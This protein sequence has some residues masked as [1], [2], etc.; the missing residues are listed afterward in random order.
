MN[1]EKRI[2][3]NNPDRLRQLVHGAQNNNQEAINELCEQYKPLILKLASN[4]YFR[5]YLDEDIINDAWEI[6]IRY[7]K[8]YDGDDFQYLPGLIKIHIRY[9]LL[10]LCK[11]RKNIL[12]NT[13]VC[14]ENNEQQL[15]D[16]GSC[17]RDFETRTLVDD[18]LRRLPYKQRI[19]LTFIFIEGKTLKE[20]S[21]LTQQSYAAVRSQYRKGMI[22][23]K[24]LTQ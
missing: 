6:F 13:I 24:K 9:E 5:E 23:F 4:S 2:L 16:S 17:I 20:I 10:K 19:V 15:S 21:E 11:K 3:E 1:T 8:R 18:I 12:D 22:N 14:D 7:I